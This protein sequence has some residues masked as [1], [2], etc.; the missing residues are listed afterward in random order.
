MSIAQTTIRRFGPT[1]RHC[2]TNAGLSQGQLAQ[3]LSVTQG[4][5]SRIETGQVR[6]SLRMALTLA[7]FFATQGDPALLS[8]LMGERHVRTV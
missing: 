8:V 3:C 2:R 7:Q 1:L 6:P 5:L 4:H